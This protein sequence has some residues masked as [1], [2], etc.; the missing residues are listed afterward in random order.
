G[1]SASSKRGPTPDTLSSRSRLPNAPCC[2][3]QATMRC[4]NAGPTRGSRVIS[5]TSARSRSMRSPGASGRARL[6]ARRAVSRRPEP[7]EDDG[8]WSWTSPGGDFGE[9]ERRNRTPAPARARP[10]RSRAA[11]LS[12]IPQPTTSVPQ[13]ITRKTP[14][15]PHQRYGDITDNLQARR[16]HFVDRILGCVVVRKSEVDHIDRVDASLLQRDVVVGKRFTR[17]GREHPPVAEALGGVPNALHNLRRAR[18]RIALLKELKVLIANH[19]EQDRIE[20]GVARRQV[21]SE[22]AR[23]EQGLGGIAE[24]TPVLTIHEKK[25]DSDQRGARF[26]GVGDTEQDGDPRGAVVGAGHRQL[27]LTE[28]GT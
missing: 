28:V 14:L 1:S 16:A 17:G 15:L 3:R 22:V 4:A 8:D 20:R 21:R 18:D 13:P 25:I 7:G 19:V 9:G 2:S 11:R 26:Q 24:V 12:F 5:V 27:L 23:A 6:A 10:A